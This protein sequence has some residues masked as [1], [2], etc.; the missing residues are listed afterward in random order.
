VLKMMNS[1]TGGTSGFKGYSYQT[2]VFLNEM[3]EEDVVW[4]E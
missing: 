3:L 4:G 1:M 2:L